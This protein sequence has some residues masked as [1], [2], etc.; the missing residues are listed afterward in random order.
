MGII[1]EK[2]M[3]E[4]YCRSDVWDKCRRITGSEPLVRLKGDP[5][6]HWEYE[7]FYDGSSGYGIIW[8]FDRKRG[9]NRAFRCA[10]GLFSRNGEK[11][12]QV[13]IDEKY[14]GDW[15]KAIL[16]A[17]TFDNL[18]AEFEEY[19]RNRRKKFMDKTMDIIQQLRPNLKN[20][21]QVKSNSH[22]GI[23][24]LLRVLTRTMNEQGSSIRT[25]AKVQYSVCLQAGIYIPD[26]F[27]TDVLVAVDMTKDLDE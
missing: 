2:A 24:N 1:G 4:G 16:K 14:N 26:E 7:G 13:F 15:R 23:A 11:L 5:I 6:K 25:I 19:F 8:D 27:I 3:I 20:I 18:F 9:R 17:K 12:C 10:V 21:K 22:G